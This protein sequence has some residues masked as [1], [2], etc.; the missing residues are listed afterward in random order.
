MA[1]EGKEGSRPI[2][3]RADAGDYCPPAR[4]FLPKERVRAPREG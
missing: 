2:G 1:V 3:E 4:A